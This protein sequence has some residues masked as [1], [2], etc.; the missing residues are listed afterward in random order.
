MKSLFAF[1][2]DGTL[3][4]EAYGI[5]ETTKVAIDACK[6]NGY[7]ICLCTGRAVG[8]I[9]ED[10]FDLNVDGVIAGGGSYIEFQ[11]KILKNALKDKRIYL[12]GKNFEARPEL[13]SFLEKLKCSYDIAGEIDDIALLRLL[14]LKSNDIVAIPEMGVINDIK[15]KELIIFESNVKISQKFYAITRQK[16]I[17]NSVI[18]FLISEM[19]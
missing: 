10:V 12:P 13:D 2:I 3:R 18:P 1:D 6:A 4:D 19:Q 16:R 8:T 14:A 9:P 15:T 7:Y 17:P 5:P 11:D